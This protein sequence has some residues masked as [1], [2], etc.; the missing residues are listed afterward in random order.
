[1]ATGTTS[2]FYEPDSATHHIKVVCSSNERRGY[3][4]RSA[5]FV[6]PLFNGEREWP[7]QTN[8]VCRYDGQPFDSI[9]IPLP[10]DHNTE[11]NTYSC[12]GIFCS[13]ACVKAFM[14]N[15]PVYSNAL[16]MIWLKKIMC[17]IF[18]DFDDIVEAPPIDLLINHGGE[19]TI[20]Q[21]RGFGRQKTRII[22]HRMPFF[23]C[24]LAF[25]LVKEYGSEIKTVEKESRAFKKLHRQK[26]KKTGTVSGGLQSQR[27][28]GGDSGGNGGSGGGNGD[29]SVLSM[30]HP[31]S[32]PTHP[33][34]NPTHPVDDF[35][36]SVLPSIAQS[37]NLDRQ[38]ISGHG[39]TGGL[40]SPEEDL[41]VA[42]SALT[43]SSL[44][45]D[46]RGCLPED[47]GDP[48]GCL[49]E[50]LG[51]PT[52]DSP[53]MDLL[54]DTITLVPAN[55]GNRWEIRGLQRPTAP[56]NIPTPSAQPNTK[57]LFQEYI[58]KRSQQKPVSDPSPS[59]S[60]THKRRGRPKSTRTKPDS[61]KH[62]TGGTLVSFLKTKQ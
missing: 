10:V 43:L 61:P 20:E 36:S 9:P 1:M 31:G 16:S 8:V 12:Y 40:D 2:I 47:F 32:N 58:E 50:D 54:P 26:K 28:S 59:E 55:V 30:I 6:H 29:V 33:G 27:M 4:K 62:T 22:T 48:S 37:Q 18:G 24:A 14:E 15:N 39:G 25:E 21:F 38:N 49:P 11:T 42:P 3:E 52:N 35:M 56:L 53:V 19:L 23:T 41:C 13:A 7:H 51:D 57:S 34:S 45:L 17:E 5:F 46:P 60:K 44:H